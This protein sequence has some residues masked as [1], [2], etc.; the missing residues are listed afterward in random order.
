LKK[1]LNIFLLSIVIIFLNSCGPVSKFNEVTANV[2]T[3]QLKKLMIDSL[4]CEGFT[5]TKITSTTG[6]KPTET[7]LEFE[8]DNPKRVSLDNMEGL[9]KAAFFLFVNFYSDLDKTDTSVTKMVVRFKKGIVSKAINYS[10][11]DVLVGLTNFYFE[12]DGETMLKLC[13]IG[14][15]KF[16]NECEFPF[17]AGNYYL[18]NGK[19]KLALPEFL[20]LMELKPQEPV[21]IG[22]FANCYYYLDSLDKAMATV[23]NCLLA[24]P[25]YN[26]GYLLRGKIYFNKG[27]YKNAEKDLMYAYK[28]DSLKP[29]NLFWVS[30]LN[31]ALNNYSDAFD[32]VNKLIDY[33]PNQGNN[34]FL[35]GKIFLKLKDNKKASVEFQKATELGSDS[36]KI[37]LEKL[38]VK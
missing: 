26:F 17:N 24:D 10:F 27:D 38:A 30:N 1:T 16:P 21:Y 25:N 3:P 23:N 14:R 29:M 12:R 2:E 34:Y 4:G 31:L 7:T 36:A 6:S 20:R 22:G 9:K 13:D 19:S 18:Q 5:V 11:C 8:L 37:Y 33:Y 28:G 32:Y 15:K 35:R